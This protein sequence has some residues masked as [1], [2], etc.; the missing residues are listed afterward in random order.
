MKLHHFIKA[1]LSL[2]CK[3]LCTVLMSICGQHRDFCL[4]FYP[5]FKVFCL[6]LQNCIIIRIETHIAAHQFEGYD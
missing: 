1:Q 6:L 4:V 2:T 5:L 3:R